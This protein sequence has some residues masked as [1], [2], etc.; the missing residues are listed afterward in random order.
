MAF[1]ILALAPDGYRAVFMISFVMA[2]IGLAVIVLLVENRT[3][4]V[5]PQP[6]AGERPLAILRNASVLRIVAAGA[7]LGALTATDALIYLLI[8]RRGAM[9]TT[10]FPLLFVGTAGHV[11]VLGVYGLL[12]AP[13]FSIASTIATVALLGAYY[14]ATDG[15][16][17]ALAT[18]R[19]APSQLS[20]GL[21]V[22]GT[23]AAL[24]RLLAASVF[25]ALWT[26]WQ[27]SGALLAFAA[28]LVVA[29][30]AAGVLLRID[31]PW[32]GRSEGAA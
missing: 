31:R 19:L 28:G 10:F 26:W 12:L 7:M 14:A 11:A 9:P 22:V 6:A 23:A 32:T 2:I 25:G 5:L 27:P 21:S 13:A 30:I 17:P 8:Q 3:P 20:T 29:T 15:V 18:T 4:Q 1:G 16:L 24:A